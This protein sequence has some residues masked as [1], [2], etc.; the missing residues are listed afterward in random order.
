MGEP[1]G[2]FADDP[3]GEPTGVA[4]GEICVDPLMDDLDNWKLNRELPLGDLRE[5]GLL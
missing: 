3:M 2:E 1:K 5:L 4:T